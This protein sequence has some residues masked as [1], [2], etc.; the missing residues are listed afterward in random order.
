MVTKSRHATFRRQ[1]PC[2][3]AVRVHVHS[4]SWSSNAG[5]GTS[6]G[7]AAGARQVDR[8]GAGLMG[9]RSASGWERKRGGTFKFVIVGARDIS[10]CPRALSG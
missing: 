6:I 1:P 4:F 7:L 2:A 3:R 8:P 10:P 5:V 9:K